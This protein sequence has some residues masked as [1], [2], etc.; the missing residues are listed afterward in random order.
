MEIAG[1]F[2]AVTFSP[3]DIHQ[4][5]VPVDENTRK[6]Q[7][8]IGRGEVR[9]NKCPQLVSAKIDDDLLVV[10]PGVG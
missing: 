2:G 10:S 8:G 1:P 5:A 4:L 3:G 7:P 6:C 9:G